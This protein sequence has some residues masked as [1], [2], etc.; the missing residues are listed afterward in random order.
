MAVGIFTDKYGHPDFKGMGPAFKTIFIVYLLYLILLKKL[1][2][3]PMLL[4]V[5]LFYGFGNY[6]NA[7]ILDY[8]DCTA[9]DLFLETTVHE[10]YIESAIILFTGFFVLYLHN[11]K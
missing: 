4:V 10:K 2:Y 5:L 3:S 9:E 1:K 7:V 11:Q 6:L 8:K